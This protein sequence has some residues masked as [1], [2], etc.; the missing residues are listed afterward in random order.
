MLVSTQSLLHRF[1]L[2]AGTCATLVPAH[3][4][5][6]R[7]FIVPFVVWRLSVRRDAAGHRRSVVAIVELA[8]NCALC[9]LTVFVFLE[10]PFRWPHEPD[11]W[12]RFMW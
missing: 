3:L 5:E 7:Y 10:R 9:A 6:C 8:S 1:A 2:A 4:L 11:D 12:Q